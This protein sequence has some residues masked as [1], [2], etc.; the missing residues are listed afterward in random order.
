MEYAWWFYHY[1]IH[2]YGKGSM[3]E[4][5]LDTE[6]QNISCMFLICG[7]LLYL[8]FITVFV[9]FTVAFKTYCSSFSMQHPLHW[10]TAFFWTPFLSC[11]ST[12][13][14]RCPYTHVFIVVQS[15]Y[16]ICVFWFYLFL[17]NILKCHWPINSEGICL[18]IYL[19]YFTCIF[20]S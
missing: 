6:N 13:M 18:F 4:I 8:T 2:L 5:V 10:D 20:T 17:F 16:Y 12:V 11:L 1:F 9:G 7:K 3:K 19:S 15:N 14:P